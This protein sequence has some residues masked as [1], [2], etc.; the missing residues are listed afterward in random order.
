MTLPDIRQQIDQIDSE[1]IAL[2]ARRITLAR[3]ARAHK[4]QVLDASREADVV[5]HW[6]VEATAQNIDPD[7]A[8]QLAETIIRITRSAQP[9]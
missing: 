7:A 6:R 4:T 5:H 1:L 8:A 2:L 9:Q 3:K